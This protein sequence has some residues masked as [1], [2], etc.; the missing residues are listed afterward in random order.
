ML[1]IKEDFFQNNKSKLF[2]QYVVTAFQVKQAAD[3]L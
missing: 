2:G 3:V 1:K